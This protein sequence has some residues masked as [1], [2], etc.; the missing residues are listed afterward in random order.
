VLRRLPPQAA[1]RSAASSGN[2]ITAL[3]IAGSYGGSAVRAI[4]HTVHMKTER[5]VAFLEGAAVIGIML[6]LMWVIEIVNRID[7]QKLDVDGIYPRTLNGLPGIISSPFLHASF[8][9]LIGNTIPFVILG[10]L[11]AF[12]GARR[13]LEVTVIVGLVAGLGTWL[14][15]GSGSSTIGASGI[16]FGYA[17]YLIA[18]A[19]FTRRIIELGVA[20]LVAVLFGGALAWDLV[21][22]T[23]VSW[24][25]HLFGALGGV[26]A[27][28][29]LTGPQRRAGRHGAAAALT[30]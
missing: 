24:E 11:V 14:T 29:L 5:R 17:G 1:S 26:L 23:G 18:R 30:D 12:D 22:K 4:G 2:T 25:D 6:A 28:Y 20:V 15:A 27:A 21:P 3:E 19:Y 13:V 7:G 8:G 9:H 10:L 16:V